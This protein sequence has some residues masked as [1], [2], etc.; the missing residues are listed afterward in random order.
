M[1]IRGGLISLLTGES[2]ISAIVGSRVYMGNAPQ[3]AKLP[4]IVLTQNGSQ[5][6]IALDGTGALRFVDF[7][8]D[9]KSETSA[10][11]E[12]L[13]KTV[14][15]YLDDY[16]GTAGTET[17]AAVLMNSENTDVEP[18]SDKSDIPIHTNLL[19]VTIQY[20]ES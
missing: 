7:D 10:Q 13:G 18:P 16:T 8:I 15:Q 14:R 11:A 20:Q 9:C 3:S 4:Y 19:D 17:I 5:E 12:T 2:T 1:S 6:N